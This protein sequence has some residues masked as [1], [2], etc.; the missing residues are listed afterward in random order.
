[1]QHS[2]KLYVKLQ[3]KCM[4]TVVKITPPDVNEL[5][6]VIIGQVP[7]KR[8][9]AKSNG[10]VFPLAHAHCATLKRGTTSHGP[11]YEE[12]RGLDMTKDLCTLL[13]LATTLTS[14]K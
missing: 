3:C 6:W 7:W 1:M 5:Y 10:Q 8:V 9:Q 4:I 2:R 14:R 11:H 12:G 13:S